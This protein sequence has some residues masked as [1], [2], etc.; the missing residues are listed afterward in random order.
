LITSQAIR[1]GSFGCVRRVERT[2]TRCLTDWNDNAKSFRWIKTAAPIKRGIH[3]AELI[4][5]IEY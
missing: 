3:N 4:Y 1:R 5:G 2:I